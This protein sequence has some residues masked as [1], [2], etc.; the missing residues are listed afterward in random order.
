MI[1]IITGYSGPGGSTSALR[2]LCDE[3]NARDIACEMYGPSDWFIKNP[4]H[5]RRLSELML[6]TKDRII[7]HWIDLKMK[8]K[9]KTIFSCHEMWWFDFNNVTDFYHE[10]QFLTEKQKNY[11]TSRSN[12]KKFFL[13]PNLKEKLEITKLDSSKNV[14]G[15]IGNIDERKNIHESIKRAL[16]EG[17]EKVLVFGDILSTPYFN[18]KIKPLLNDKVIYMG[19]KDKS[20]IYSN[21]DRVYHMS[22]G[23]VASLVKDECYTTGTM[24]FGNEETDNEVSIMTNDEII[25]SWKEK[26]EL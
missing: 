24:F 2:R 5:H 17:S 1:K 8:F 16:D 19:H 9:Q 26:L 15:V 14:A 4:K 21:I 6:P 13:L 23:E 25:T 7:A 18:E 3:F 20:F 22:K 12:I 11:H 10:V